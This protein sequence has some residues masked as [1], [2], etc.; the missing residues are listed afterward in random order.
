MTANDC[1]DQMARSRLEAGMRGETTRH[2]RK[3]SLASQHASPQQFFAKGLSDEPGHSHLQGVWCR[4]PAQAVRLMV[5]LSGARGQVQRPAVLPQEQG[6]AR[7][8]NL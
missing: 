2:I 6:P 3:L 5:L 7:P 4:V 1:L 8:Q